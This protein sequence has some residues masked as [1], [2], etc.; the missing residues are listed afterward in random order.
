MSK[1][2][3]ICTIIIG[4]LI[5]FSFGMIYINKVSPNEYIYHFASEAEEWAEYNAEQTT[6]TIWMCVGAAIIVVG[7]C[8]IAAAGRPQRT[9]TN[10]VANDNRIR[11]LEE[12]VRKLESEKNPQ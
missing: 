10:N 8:G 12:K 3:W 6:N 1:G 2:I 11:E 9:Q 4:G 7:I 5:I